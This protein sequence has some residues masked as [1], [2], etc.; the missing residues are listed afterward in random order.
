M[1]LDAYEIDRTEVT[2]K[3]YATCESLG[4]CTVPGTGSFS[5][6]QEPGMGS[7]PINYVTWFQADS[8]CVWAGKELC[9]EAQWEKGA[10][11]GCEEN[12]GPSN[13]N[14]QSRKYPWGKDAPTCDLAALDGCDGNT[15]NV[16]TLSPDGDS[17]YGLCDMAGNVWE[18]VADRYQKDYYCNGDAATGEEYC[19]EC[20]S[21]PGHP[22]AWSNPEGPESG[23]YRVLRGGGFGNDY[24]F[25]RV[26]NRSGYISSTLESTLGFRCCKSDCGDGLCNEAGG[27]DCSNC[28]QDCGCGVGDVCDNGTCVP[29]V[30]TPDCAGKDCGDDGCGGI[31]GTCSN[32]TFCGP[33]ACEEGLCVPATAPDCDDGNVCTDDSCP[34][35][36]CQ[37]EP[38]W[39]QPCDDGEFCSTDDA[40]AGVDGTVCEGGGWEGCDD[41][42]P[43]TSDQCIPGGTGCYN[44]HQDG[45]CEDGDLC[46]EGDICVEGACSP[47][48]LNACDDGNDCTGVYC[49]PTAGCTYP[50]LDGQP[51]DD[52]DECTT[53]DA[54]S[55]D[56]CT[57]LGESICWFDSTSGLTWQTPSGGGSMIWSAAKTYCLNLP[58]AGGGWHLPTIGELRTLIRGCP[59]SVTGGA[60]DV[61]DSCLSLSCWNEAACW[62][63][64]PGFGPADGVYWPDEMQ[65]A[66]SYH[67]SSSSVADYSD[68][69]AWTVYFYAGEVYRN[70]F[71]SVFLVRCVH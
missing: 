27:E 65:G 39:G 7:H 2:E 48:A 47:G 11:G 46:T 17:P 28:I 68:S 34:V 43:C 16:C 15:K 53:G 52:G 71:S 8:Y 70:A 22:A 13:C 60:C 4:A 24:N 54:C 3:Q 38:L 42:N 14:A 29:E 20:G 35:D 56:T 37:H 40:C 55:S 5:T 26:S 23:S 12:G 10:R 57:A 49:D 32:G 66:F 69:H 59:G 45:G 61:T 19:T 67:W 58:L 30:C 21:W 1:C 25:L 18:W 36:A 51:C 6:W 33:V 31:C 9:T 62:S 63:C 50:V 64:S 41:G 44:T